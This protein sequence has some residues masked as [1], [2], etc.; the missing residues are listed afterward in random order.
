MGNRE[1]K[2]CLPLSN[3]C[4]DHRGRFSAGNKYATLPRR[5]YLRRGRKLRMAALKAVTPQDMVAVMQVLVQK[6][7]EGSVSAA[8][9]VLGRALGKLQDVPFEFPPVDPVEREAAIQR[10]VDELRSYGIKVG[11][12]ENLYGERVLS[13]GIPDDLLEELECS[14]EAAPEQPEA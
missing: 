10:A 3:G 8:R 14:G 2:E 9:E 5:A 1:A 6:A 12:V 7:R 11:V 4:R 13:G